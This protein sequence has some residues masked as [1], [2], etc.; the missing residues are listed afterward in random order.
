MRAFS[1]F[2]SDLFLPKVGCVLPWLT[3]SATKMCHGMLDA[4]QM[5]DLDYKQQFKAIEEAELSRAHP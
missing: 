2:V 4:K 3:E 5:W 1:R